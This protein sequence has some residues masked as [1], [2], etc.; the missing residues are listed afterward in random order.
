[1]FFLQRTVLMM[2]TN[3]RMPTLPKVHAVAGLPRWMLLH[4]SFQK[5]PTI[6][7]PYPCRIDSESYFGCTKLGCI[8]SSRNVRGMVTAS[9]HATDDIDGL[10]DGALSTGPS[11]R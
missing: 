10:V 3:L 9:A 2:M 5:T 8:S 4:T 11:V 1:M 7:T 6:V